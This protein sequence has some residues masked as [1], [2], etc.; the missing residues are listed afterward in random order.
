MLKPHPLLIQGGMGAG[1]SG[2]HLARTVAR[3]GHL[4][5]VSGTALDVILAR[6]LQQGDPGGHLRRALSAFPDGQMA[7][8][9]LRRYYIAGG[10]RSVEPY[11][12]TPL[13]SAPL[14]RDLEELLI[15]AN[16][17][18]VFL[19]RDGH[20]GLI[21]INFLEKIQTTLLP[22]LYGA[23]L[24]GVDIVLMGA[25]IPWQVPGV[26]DALQRQE[27]VQYRLTV[28]GAVPGED[29]Q[30]E[31]EPGAYPRLASQTLRRPA[32]LAIV[33]SSTLAAALLKR[34]TGTIE[35][36]VIEGH[37]AGGHNAPPRGALRLDEHGQP[38]Y[39]ERDVV[40]LEAFRG[41]GLPFWLAG[42]YGDPSRVTEALDAGAAG[43]QVGTAFALCE[44][45][46]VDPLLR[47]RLLE[48]VRSGTAEVY[49]DPTASTTGFPFKVA[50]LEG[51]MSEE[52]VC[53]ERSRLCDLGYLRQLYR[54]DDGSIG[55]RCPGEPV[56]SFVAKGGRIED[57]HGRKCLCN[58]LLATIG[59]GQTRPSGYQE[60]PI[61]T[62]GDALKDIARTYLRGGPSYTAAD[63]IDLLTRTPS[64]PLP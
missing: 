1:V 22:S 35:G 21:G 48:R 34:A 47:G 11:R 32:F 3:L 44:E 61:V 58:G 45:S 14:R 28:T 50:Q 63:V 26:L 5:V 59:L 18:E 17:C 46:G 64:A 36:F 49:T 53:R 7:E 38:V 13:P 30:V 33:A 52:R 54:K 55:Y 12:R 6:K 57:T 31:F 23:M 62:A 25:G 43:V 29:H 2:W 39:G 9:I 41:F 19:A 20:D 4:G 8:S 42:G 37:T 56:E 15:A 27:R 24:A 51:T 60:R 40:D 10:K 16:Y